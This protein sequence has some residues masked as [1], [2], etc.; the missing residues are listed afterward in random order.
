MTVGCSER[1]R[2]HQP[3]SAGAAQMITEDQI[4]TFDNAA[5]G[6]IGHGAL[7][8][9]PIPVIIAVAM[10]LLLWGLTR[11]TALGL[12]IEAAGINIRSAHNTGVNTR[13]VLMVVY[14]LCG[15][16]AAVAGIIITADI[17]GGRCQQCRFVAGAGRHFGGGHRWRLAFRRPFLFAVIG[18]G[19]A[20]SSGDEHRYFAFRL[21]ARI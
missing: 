9:L 12:F 3:R 19:S 4:V 5:F 8:W 1:D 7:L 6:E 10:L 18:S 21:P 2:S 13:L 11:K 20:D 14:M 17:S 16:C 15:L